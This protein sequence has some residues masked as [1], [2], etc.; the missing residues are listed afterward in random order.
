M[1]LI[2]DNQDVIL[3]AMRLVATNKE[4]TMAT[5]KISDL[6]V[7]DWVMNHRGYPT[8]VQVITSDGN[9][10][11]GELDAKSEHC[12]HLWVQD[13]EPIPITAEILEKNGFTR[14]S[15]EF[16]I[17]EYT[18][19]LGKMLRKIMVSLNHPY[20]Y[21]VCRI[22]DTSKELH[23]FDRIPVNTSVERNLIHIHDLQ[24]A[25]RLAGVDKEIYL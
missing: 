14:A 6:S 21:I 8:K 9:L 5:L 16:P 20:S 2:A 23:E 3:S 24:H 15:S 10:L 22:E 17:Y 7:G 19:L 12:T 1:K 25:L 13:I 11:C 18:T 4:T